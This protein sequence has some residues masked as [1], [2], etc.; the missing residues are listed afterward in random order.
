VLDGLAVAV[1]G[2]GEPAIAI[3]ADHHR[4]QGGRPAATVLGPGD[5]AKL[6]IGS[7]VAVTGAAMH[8]LDYEPTWSPA[9]HALSTTLPAVL[10][11]AEVI[12]ASPPPSSM[13][14]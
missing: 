2:A 10:A 7:A 13:G 6:P 5:G 12:G 11:L 3:L 14:P 9:N 8:V 1:A 4:A